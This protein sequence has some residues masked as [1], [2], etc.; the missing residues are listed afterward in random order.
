[1]I[2][3]AL[4]ADTEIKTSFGRRAGRSA[5]E[6]YAAKV[7]RASGWTDGLPEGGHQDGDTST[8]TQR[9]PIGRCAE[10]HPPRWSVAPPALQVRWGYRPSRS[11]GVR[12]YAALVHARGG[13]LV[14]SLGKE[15]KSALAPPAAYTPNQREH[16]VVRAFLRCGFFLFKAQPTQK[17]VSPTGGLFRCHVRDEV[18]RSAALT[19]KLSSIQ[20]LRSSSSPPLPSPPPLSA[21]LCLAHLVSH[22]HRALESEHIPICLS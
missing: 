1:M 20:N 7:T 15:K 11:D 14:L 13:T 8:A 4:D 16:T 2:E 22:V 3:H 19:F 6:C 18:S 17:L 9:L 5:V 10:I 21:L 12:E